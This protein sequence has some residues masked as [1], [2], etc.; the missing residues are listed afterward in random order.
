MNMTLITIPIDKIDVGVRIRERVYE[1]DEFAQN[2]EN[3][4]LINP[5]TVM[6]LNSGRY[7][8][9]AG[10][11]RYEAVK[12]LKW[13]DISAN[14]LPL[15]DAEETLLIEI[16][17][18]TQRHN[19]TPDE[20]AKYGRLLEAI[21]TEKAKERIMAGKKSEDPLVERTGGLVRDI[22]GEKLGISG[23]QYTRNKYIADHATREDKDAIARKEKSVFGVYSELRQVDK[24]KTAPVTPTPASQYT[25]DDALTLAA[26]AENENSVLKRQLENE[27]SKREV[28]NEEFNNRLTLVE[29]K[30]AEIKRLMDENCQLKTENEQLKIENARLKALINF[31]DT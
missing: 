13:S 4:G 16:S 10:L 20:I 17:E 11:R 1:L 22:V 9:L 18:N 14:V 8:L 19:F 24:P 23:T 25:M 6:R 26:K 30:Q 3:H 27:K 5:I 15:K 28:L 31:Q 21:E 12:T 2:I 7:R 29:R